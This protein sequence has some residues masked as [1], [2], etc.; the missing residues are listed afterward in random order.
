MKKII[1]LLTFLALGAAS[2]MAQVSFTLST[3]LTVGNNDQC[4]TAADVNGDGKVDL[5]SANYNDSTLSV[6]TNTGAGGFI[7]SSLLT[8]GLNPRT[9]IAA[10]VNGDGAPDIITANYGNN[11][12]SVLTNNGH[13][14][15]V[16][17]STLSVS[18]QAYAVAA[19]DVN[20]DGN[21]DLISANYGN[22]TLSVFTNNAHGGFV[23]ASSYPVGASPGAV[24]AADINGDGKVDL[25][26]ANFNANTLS[27]LTNNGTGGFVLSATIG[28]GNFPTSVTAAD[29][30]GDGKSDLI[31]ANWGNNNLWVL[32]NNGSGG[33][34]L[35]AILDVGSYPTYVIAADINGDSKLDLISANSGSASQS[36]L[37]NNGN[38][39]F[40]LAATLTTGNLPVTVVA[41][42]VNGDGKPDLISANAG[43]NTLSVYT[44]A[45][46]FPGPPTAPVITTQPV[47]RTN[48]AGTN[49]TFTVAATANGP[50]QARQF[51]YQWQ[52]G[53]TNLASATNSQL[54]LNN[55]APGQSGTYDVIVSNY[56]GSVTSSVVTLNV[57]FLLATVN[58]QQVLGSATAIAS[59]QVAITGG[60]P[61]GFL[62]YTLDGSTPTTSST[63]YT[64]PFTLTNSAVLGMLALSS[65]FSQSSLGAPL[66]IQI[67]PVYSL[68]TAVTGSGS[69]SLN[70]PGGPYT[71]NTM[72]TL[73]ATAITNWVFDHWTGDLTGSQNP[74]TV[75][76][77]G[78][79]S[80][81]AV[82]VP[83]AFPLTLATL[84]G[85]SVTAN[86]QT[87][88][89][90]AYFP[91]GGIVNLAATAVSGWS[92]L[93]WQGD[94]TG[95]NNPLQV[96]MNQARI[97]Q[98]IFGTT[99]LS[100]IVG[101]GNIVLAQPNPVPYGTALTVSA[102][103]N[104]GNYFV[105]WA[106]LAK[107]T[108][109]PTTVLVTNT[110]VTNIVGALFATLPSGKY[111]LAAV[112][113][114][115]GSV[116]IT[117]QQDYYNP[118][119]S[120]T[121]TASTTN[122]G[123]T[124]NGWTGDASG[125]SNTITVV[126]T[127][128]KVV[129]ANFN[130]APLVSISPTNI[131]LLEGG[132]TALTANASGISPFNY[133]W[134]DSEGV[135]A[136]QTNAILTI[137]NDQASDYYSVIVSNS[138]GSITSA[139]VSVTVAFPPS[140]NMEPS[141][142]IVADG[143]TASLGVGASG[144]APMNFQWYDSLGAI[145]NATNPVYTLNPAH[146][147]D[148]DNYFVII[149]NAYGSVTSSVAG[150]VVYQPVT[151]TAQPL[152]QVVPF[153]APASFGVL[154]TGFPAP[155]Y[156]WS[157]NGTNI[158]GANSNLLAI[159]SVR[160]ANAGNYQVFVGNGYS[161]TSSQAASL[162]ISPTITTPFLGASPIWGRSAELSVGAQGT[163]NL[164]FQWYLNGNAISGAT[165]SILDFSSIQFTDGGLYSVV[166]SSDYGSVSNAPAQVAVNPAGLSLGF[167]PSLTITGVVGNTY[168]I[169]SS[170]NLGDTNN[171]VTL[172]NLTLTS[173]VQLWVD[174][175]VNASSPFV[176]KYFYQVLPGQ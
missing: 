62:F 10:D 127:T 16:L 49:V 21:L 39:G 105:S 115:L 132:G 110:A 37:T 155:V 97:I 100:N 153:G 150:L 135:I 147:N 151:I 175:N 140:I 116:A 94:A 106:Q 152:S 170:T 23:L 9:V 13:G 96:T 32:T 55:V 1:L 7:L 81:Q 108:N 41:T 148:W 139:V 54:V 86:G 53:G 114:G 24:I 78:P 103:P 56:V 118:G 112:V 154:A 164:A 58:G 8:V 17:A 47:G 68:Q 129:E 6:F 113:A 3:N 131:V 60:Y 91:A 34:T 79:R 66:S 109:T 107:G 38:G 104:P 138:F 26:S 158:N 111:S 25:I 161:S 143:T 4:V 70:P 166:V 18:S 128:N 64:G 126:M 72:V 42:D 125:T 101:G 90:G 169:Q 119:D 31:C 20:G 137:T 15:F 142:Q 160:I 130:S 146:T 45:T 156:Q 82:F 99:V 22:S 75:T 89:P 5:I 63:L 117:P 87:I 122:S 73:T 159:S 46:L 121:L 173:P 141:G 77:N 40:A 133:Q 162:N 157:L 19:A 92:F 84:G 61:G 174:T 124:F 29:V 93:N 171:W 167:C 30:N 44:N 57:Q 67:I 85:G 48:L 120:V 98:G 11:S 136:G 95:T 65:D 80:V 51:T 71:S 88:S 76:M 144:T 59:A 43:N 36:V 50:A 102:V 74:A 168:I 52:F 69:I 14:G 2:T 28:V 12:L 134:L 145:P 165:N 27:I 123:T 83:T 176:T 149:T 163:G 35:S 33:F 172:T